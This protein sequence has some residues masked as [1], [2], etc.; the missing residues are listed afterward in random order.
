MSHVIRS[1]HFVPLSIKIKR[2]SI[3]SILKKVISLLHE[4]MYIYLCSLKFSIS[5]FNYNIT[6]T[7]TTCTDTT[8]TLIIPGTI[9]LHVVPHV[10][11]LLKHYYYSLRA[12]LWERNQIF[13]LK[14]RKQNFE[15]DQQCPLFLSPCQPMC[16]IVTQS[17]LRIISNIQPF[18]F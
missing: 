9:A 17:V 16:E 8:T 6:T 1:R 15:N 18:L 2:G 4:C 11:D 5:I 10:L 7:C 3:T 13:I 14:T 12:L